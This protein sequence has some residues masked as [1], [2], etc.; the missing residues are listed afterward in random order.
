MIVDHRTYSIRPGKVK[1]W[2]E[3]YEKFAL[4]VQAKHLGNLLGFFVS[5]IGPLNQIVFMWGY[6]DL[7]DR[8]RRR[9]TMDA[10]PD[11]HAYLPNPPKLGRSWR[12]R[13]R[14]CGRHR[15][16]RL[17]SISVAARRHTIDHVEPAAGNEK[18]ADN[19]P[20]VGN[21]SP[22]NEA[23]D[24]CPYQHGVPKRGE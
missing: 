10:D 22:N 19:R 6:D 8:D 11:W 7:G 9:A 20:G 3:N 13:T 21:V 23:D 12:K 1:A 16:R 14:S 24:Q 18:G 2:L 5:E 4:P 15:S 17:S